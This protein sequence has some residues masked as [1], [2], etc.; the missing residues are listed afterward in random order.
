MAGIFKANEI[1]TAAEEI[2]TRGET[3][4]Q[5][6]VDSSMDEGA[7]EVFAFLRD[8]ESKHRAI[9]HAM[10]ERLAPVELPAWAEEEEFLNYINAMIEDH[11]LFRLADAAGKEMTREEGI[12]MA[13][14]FEKDTML[15]F[16]EM[17]ELVPDSEKDVVK[18]CID[19][20]RSHLKRLM[21]LQ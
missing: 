18:K 12:R 14:Q 9:F 3:F 17:R 13:M 4:Y 20:E 2:E 7:K 16:A 5:R 15:F 21:A 11:A 8:E 19:E 6:L 1:I 10:G